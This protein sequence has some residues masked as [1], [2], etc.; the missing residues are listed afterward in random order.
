MQEMDGYLI[1]QWK[2]NRQKD[3]LAPAT[4]KSNVKHIKTFVNW[5]ESSSLVELGIGEK[6]DI[7]QIPEADQASHKHITLQTAQEILGYLETYQYASR[8]H[9]LFYTLWETGC[10]ISGAIALDIGDFYPAERKLEFVDRKE[11]GTS[12]KNGPKGERNVT[13]SEELIGVL[14]DYIEV[15]R[16]D[17]RD[18]YNRRPLFTTRTQRLTRQRAYKNV[19]AFSRPCVYTNDCPHNK[20]IETCEAAQKKAKAFG[21]PSSTS[22]HPIR[23]GAITH[24]LNSGWPKDKVS[25]RCDVSIET[26]EKHYNEQTKEDERETRMKYVDRL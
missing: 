26:L 2:L 14:N 6:I 17:A 11:Q 19:V 25:D 20:D 22:M 1:E 21:C 7:P 23:R 13:I 3:D 10:R 24:H 12:L 4:F 8:Q 15:H 5:C 9:A 16:E 18:D